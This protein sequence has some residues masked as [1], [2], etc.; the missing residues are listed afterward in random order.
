MK[1]IIYNYTCLFLFISPFFLWDVNILVIEN[2]NFYITARYLV[3]ILLIPIIYSLFKNRNYFNILTIFNNQKNILYFYVF[4]LLHFF[5]TSV[6][7]N[8]T[9]KFDNIFEFSFLFFLA[10]I[11]CHYR[12]FLL[13]NFDKFIFLFFIIFICSS[14]YEEVGAFNTG[15]CQFIIY[16]HPEDSFF[17]KFFKKILNSTFSNGFYKENSHLAMT[18]VGVII[19]SIFT[20]IKSRFNNV[21]YFS[22]FIFVF[23]I[24]ILNSSTTLFISY[25]VS[26]IV[27]ILF[28]NKKIPNI[29]WFYTLILFVVFGSIFLF[30]TDCK[31]KITHFN[32]QHIAEKKI[33]KS[34]STLKENKEKNL[35]TLIYERSIILS[36]D[37]LYEKPLGWGMNNM[38]NA[39]ANLLNKP[40]YKYIHIP[41]GNPHIYAKLLN[42]KDG[43]G[44]LFKLTT[45]FGFFSFFIFYMFI[46]Y[47]INLKK[48]NS[49]QLFIIVLFVTQCLR[50][51]GY[52]NGGFI[53]C[54][55]E[56]FYFANERYQKKQSLIK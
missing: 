7:Y 31:N 17:S 4:V 20:L 23:F 2:F 16:E 27:L 19:S 54:L 32:L 21:I 44:N 8:Q 12:N 13:I 6:I 10:L 47:M 34:N 37:T 25:F 39:T 40:E 43:L 9:L 56:F 50:G 24:L 30:K 36:L 14:L 18:S 22:L 41:D 3:L 26:Q 15:S 55:F 51:A 53:F 52:F 42:L 48:I 35:T 38:D 11:Y 49:Y 46:K 45:E 1:K 29:F 28:F 33:L 5:L